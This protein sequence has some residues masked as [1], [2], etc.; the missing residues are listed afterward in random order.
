[1]LPDG[2]VVQGPASLELL[3]SDSVLVILP[4]CM[5]RSSGVVVASRLHATKCDVVETLKM[6]SREE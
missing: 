4:S 3:G 1:M 6:L 5:K 2:Q